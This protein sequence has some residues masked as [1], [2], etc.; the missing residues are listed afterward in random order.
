M[1]LPIYSLP[2]CETP[3]RVVYS[4]EYY[5]RGLKKKIPH[6]VENLPEPKEGTVYVVSNAVRTHMK[7]RTDL[8][9]PCTKV[10]DKE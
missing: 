5:G 7:D 9:S 6:A 1:T 3:A 4:E 8:A 2:A 10:K